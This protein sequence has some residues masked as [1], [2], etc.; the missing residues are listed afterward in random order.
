MLGVIRPV[1]DSVSKPFW[2]S[3]NK[4]NLHLQK[5]T[6]CEKFRFPPYENCPYCG[7]IGGDWV[8]VS[9][10]GKIYSW[11]VVHHTFEHRFREDVPY[12]VTLVELDEGPRIIGRMQNC[13]P[14]EIKAD[15]LVIGKYHRVDNELVL[16]IFEPDER[17]LASMKSN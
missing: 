13:N 4:G 3:L 5:C 14:E 9:G 8:P 11:I 17:R 10:R 12:I 7:K 16:L 2:E 1:I 15:M 6:G